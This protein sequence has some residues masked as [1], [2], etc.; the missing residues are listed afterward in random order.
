PPVQPPP[1]DYGS[2]AIACH[3]DVPKIHATLQHTTTAVFLEEGNESGEQR[4]HC[5]AEP[6]V[7][8]AGRRCQWC[9]SGIR[10]QSSRAKISSSVLQ[11]ITAS[12]NKV[13]S[14]KARSTPA[15][16]TPRR[17]SLS[18]TSVRA[19]PA[20]SVLPRLSLD[21]ESELAHARAARIRQAL[22]TEDLGSP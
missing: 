6:S 3:S 21:L 2:V 17:D 1:N 5:A 4:G 19:R 10:K 8:A 14:I 13:S 16:P 22:V 12:R 11:A 9:N 7:D 18:L 20:R 15:L